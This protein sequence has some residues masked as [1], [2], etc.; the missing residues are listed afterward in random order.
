M[1]TS[2]LPS[3]DEMYRAV[4][5]RDSRYDGIFFTA[6]RT[7]GIFCRP[8]CPARTPERANVEFYAS[9]R[10]AL[11]HGF[12]ACKR[13]RP[14]EPRGRTPEPIGR[15]LTRLE[16]KPSLRLRDRDLRDEGLEPAA[17]RRWFKTHHGMTFHA[18]Q[19]ARRMARAISQLADGREITETAF[20][21]GYESLSGFQEAIRQVTGESASRSRAANVVHLSRVLTPLGPM[22]LGTTEDAVC[23]LEFGDRRMLPTQLRRLMRQMDCVFLPGTTDAGRQLETELEGYFAGAI[24]EFNTP[25][26]TAGTPFQERAWSALRA[27]PYAETRSY[28]AQAAAIGLPNAVRAVARANGDN[29]IAIV[30]PCH[31][32]VGA[33]GTLTGYGGGLWRKRWLLDHETSSQSV[34]P[35]QTSL[36]EALRTA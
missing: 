32:V 24:R 19:R 6:V 8:G 10:D 18:Y 23:L 30:I 34:S 31:R 15:L 20:G 33:D 29:R 5:A 25:L 35:A 3:T 13:C 28:G 11:A 4:V 2:A 22:L 17:V 36:F 12:R 16:R 14:L 7:T 9:A 1:I 27:I 26:I 21:N